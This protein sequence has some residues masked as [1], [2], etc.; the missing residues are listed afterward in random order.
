MMIKHD[1]TQIHDLVAK[2]TKNPCF[3][4]RGSLKTHGFVG[5]SP[6][7]LCCTRQVAVAVTV[8]VEVATTNAVTGQANDGDL[9]GMSCGIFGPQ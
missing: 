3:S 2:T 9:M 1:K 5:S 4:L 8:T 6:K 7:I